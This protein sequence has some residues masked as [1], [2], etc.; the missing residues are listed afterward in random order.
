MKGRRLRERLKAGCAAGL[1]AAVLF[2]GRSSWYPFVVNGA[3]RTAER[4]QEF[5]PACFSWIYGWYYPAGKLE[6]KEKREGESGEHMNDWIRF[7]WNMLP[8]FR[9]GEYTEETRNKYKDPSYLS[10]RETIEFYSEYEG[11]LAIGGEDTMAE[12]PASTNIS[13]EA[14]SQPVVAGKIYDRAQL[15]DYDFLMKNFFSVHTST[16]AG[17]DI[18]N[19]E[20]LLN[21][22]LQMEIK[23]EPQILIY[24]TH[25]QETFADYGPENPEATVVGIGDYLTKLLEEKGYQVIHDRSVYDLKDGNLDRSKAYTYALEGISGILQENPSIQVVLDVHRDGVKEGY[26]MVSQVNGKDTAPVMFFNGMSQTPTGPIEYLPNPY[27]TENLAFSFQMQLK[28]AADYPGFTRKIYLKGLR[29]N[30]HLRPRSAL[31]E[32]GAQTNTYQEA[33]NAMEPLAEVLDM[34]LQGK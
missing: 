17:R 28:A 9:Y 31:I 13:K 26:H 3:E 7:S 33:L 22:N 5:F 6:A 11:L 24:H 29:Y 27:R 21:T 15:A 2:G 19:A 16:T 18:M 12:S 4:L 25:S 32:V 8:L 14:S 30:L 20:T 1:I 10:Y 34:V 23:D